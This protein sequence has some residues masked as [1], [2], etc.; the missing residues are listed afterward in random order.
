MSSV[1]FETP[2]IQIGK[3]VRERRLELGW[4]QLQ[5]AEFAGVRQATISSLEA[6]DEGVKMQTVNKVLIM[7]GLVSLTPEFK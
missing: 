4:T 1:I 7:L 5:L 2:S 6:A 3:M